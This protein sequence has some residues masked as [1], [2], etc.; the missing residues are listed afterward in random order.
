MLLPMLDEIV[1]RAAEAGIQSILLGM[2][3]RG[4]LNVVEDEV[5]AGCVSNCTRLVYRDLLDH[6]LFSPT[7]VSNEKIVAKE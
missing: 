4:R 2:A 6:S 1:G 7:L 3:H 5:E